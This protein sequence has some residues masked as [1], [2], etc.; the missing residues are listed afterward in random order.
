MQKRIKLENFQF[1]PDTLQV[2]VGTELK[3]EVLKHPGSTVISSSQRKFRIE[4]NNTESDTLYAGDV[5][6]WKSVEP[7]EYQFICPIYPRMQGTVTVVP[8]ENAW[9][10]PQDPDLVP[11]KVTP[12]PPV[13]KKLSPEKI[14][15]YNFRPLSIP[16]SLNSVIPDCESEEETKQ[17]HQQDDENQIEKLFL[18]VKEE[19]EKDHMEPSYQESDE[20]S[21]K[22]QIPPKTCPPKVYK[23][24][25]VETHSS[26]KQEKRPGAT[27]TIRAMGPKRYF[28]I[29][30]KKKQ[31]NLKTKLR[32]NP[33]VLDEI[34]DLLVKIK[35][36]KTTLNEWNSSLLSSKN[37]KIIQKRVKS[38]KTELETHFKS[39]E[40]HKRKLTE[41]MIKN[42][43]E[44]LEKPVDLSLVK[45]DVCER[46]KCMISIFGVGK[47]WWI[48][49]LGKPGKQVKV[50]SGTN[51]KNIECLLKKRSEGF[52]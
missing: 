17:T 5:F 48:D 26:E 18:K 49:K 23:C 36:S 4:I 41:K 3:F 46:R 31:K 43:N 29:E 27:F 19:C 30:S 35:E 32:K 50:F 7:G 9:T 40:S 34:F 45:E 28:G 15:A 6:T 2:T 12:V 44:F 33:K 37:P 1:V 39:F 42:T 11:L 10:N 20:E 8:K 24:T 25:S 51:W 47:N 22:P 52:F 38:L 13:E 16:S 14:R 21:H